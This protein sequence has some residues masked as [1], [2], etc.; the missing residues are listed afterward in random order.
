MAS[1]QLQ[2]PDCIY[3]YHGTY[4]MVH[5]RRNDELKEFCRSEGLPLSGT[6]RVY[7]DRIITCKSEDAPLYLNI[8][9]RRLRNLFSGA[10][11]FL[12]AKV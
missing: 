6:K 3:G 10:D 4:A 9:E 8:S 12:S 1:L 11:D 5:A 7:V 2:F